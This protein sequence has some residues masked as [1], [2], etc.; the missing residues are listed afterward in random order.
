MN[1][2]VLI[3]K[4]SRSEQIG[5]E[6]DAKL[7]ALPPDQDPVIFLRAALKKFEW[8]RD[9]FLRR[10]DRDDYEFETGDP[11]MYEYALTIAEIS[12]RLS[13][14]ECAKATEA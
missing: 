3:P 4:P 11:D 5:A 8:L 13:R 2:H 6:L 7:A 10:M 14:L 12:G 1:V 9:R